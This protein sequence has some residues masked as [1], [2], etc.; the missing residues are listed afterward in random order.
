MPAETRQRGQRRLRQTER[1]GQLAAEFRRERG[2]VLAGGGR[3]VDRRRRLVLAVPSVAAVV[4]AIFAPLTVAFREDRIIVAAVVGPLPI[5][6][7][8]ERRETGLR[9]M[10]APADKKV[11]LATAASVA[12]TANDAGLGTIDWAQAARSGIMMAVSRRET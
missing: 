10:N 3:P 4:L 1:L 8:A 6:G 2:G 5:V 12:L 9:I 11:V 7:L